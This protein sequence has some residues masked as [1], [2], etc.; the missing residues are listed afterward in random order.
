M[1]FTLNG[2]L[3]ETIH[4]F[5][6]KAGYFSLGGNQETEL[7][8]IRPLAGRSGYPRFHLYLRKQDGSTSSPQGGESWVFNLHLDQKKPIYEGTSAHSGEYDGPLVE[9]E[10]TRIKAIL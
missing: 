6:R 8:Y 2:P 7:D 10:A 1:K 9:Q 4:N 3:K 5:V